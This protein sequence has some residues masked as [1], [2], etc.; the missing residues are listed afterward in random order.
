MDPMR[1]PVTVMLDVI[2]IITSAGIV[3]QGYIC[4]GGDWNAEEQAGE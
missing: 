2:A 4:Q 3:I 1:I